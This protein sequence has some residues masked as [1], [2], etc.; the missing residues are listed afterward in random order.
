MIAIIV[1]GTTL[2]LIAFLFALKRYEMSHARIYGVAWRSKADNLAIRIKG[3]LA[4]CER[5]LEHTP[6]FVVAVLRWGVHV[7]AL[8]I[9]RAARNSERHAHRL[10]DM[11]S[12]KH[13][14]ER[15]ETRSDFLKQVGHYKNDKSK[16]DDSVATL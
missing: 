13:N 10:A 12:H 15:R 3:R 14:F 16:K 8:L 2:V 4:T 5:Y 11:V 9:A 1:F 6:D 7:L